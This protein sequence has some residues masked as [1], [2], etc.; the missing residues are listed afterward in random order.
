MGAG[1]GSGNRRETGGESALL[2]YSPGSGQS[3]TAPWH[4][5]DPCTVTGIGTAAPPMEQNQQY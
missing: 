5:P 2:T 4:I 1:G 3:P